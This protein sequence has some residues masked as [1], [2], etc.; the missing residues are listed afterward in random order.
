MGGLASLDESFLFIAKRL[1][2]RRVFLRR[3]EAVLRAV[4]TERLN[5]ERLLDRLQLASQRDE[6]S[7]GIAHVLIEWRPTIEEDSDSARRETSRAG[8]REDLDALAA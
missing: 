4:E 1:Q 3:V 2:F 7:L 6:T 8:S 5:L